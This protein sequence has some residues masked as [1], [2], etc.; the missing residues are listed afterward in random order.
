MS[1]LVL[2]GRTPEPLML[3]LKALGILQL[4]AE[5]TGPEARG[6]WRVG[7]FLLSSMFDKDAL[8]GFFLEE[9]RPTPIAAP[10]AGRLA[11]LVRTTAKPE[12]RSPPTLC[13]VCR[14]IVRSS[15][16]CESSSGSSSK[17]QGRPTM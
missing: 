14:M 9:Y 15:D 12:T 17:Q 16:S 13:C 7:V 11:F 3:Y 8:I 5:Q 2:H 10:W 1:E 6:A 4:V